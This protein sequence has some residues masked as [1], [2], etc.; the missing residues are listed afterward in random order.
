MK[1]RIVVLGAG[2]AGAFAAGNLARRL[3]LADTQITMVNAVLQ[4]PLLIPAG[5]QAMRLR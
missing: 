2:Y 3:S 5:H 1:H 4:D